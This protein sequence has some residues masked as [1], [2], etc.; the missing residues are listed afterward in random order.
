M[1]ALDP[2]RY[3]YREIACP[4][5]QANQ[6]AYCRRPSGHSGPLVEP[7][8]ERR[9]AAHQ[10]WRAEEMR[11]YGRQLTPWVDDPS[12]ATSSGAV[13]PAAPLDPL[14]GQYSLF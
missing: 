3:D 5:C 9:A 1:A 13:V 8:Q 14:N 10:L 2:T 7:H 6:G 12:P 4:Q 11:L